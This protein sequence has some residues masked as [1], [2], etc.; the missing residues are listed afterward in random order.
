MIVN[1][2]KSH[3][4]NKRYRVTLD[5]GKTYDFGLLGGE[6]YIDHHD[7]IKRQNY[8]ARH[9]ANPA[10]KELIDNFTPS[11]ATFSA[12]LLWG[13]HKTLDKNIAELNRHM[14]HMTSK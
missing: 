11:P 7:K 8:W 13:N 1:I 14:S 9:Y 12:Y 2:E 10:E 3:V 5:T 6:T 4:K